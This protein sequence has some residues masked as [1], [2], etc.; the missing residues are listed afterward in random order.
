VSLIYLIRHGTNDYVATG[1]LAGRTPGV[2][3]NEKGRAESEL[4]ALALAKCSINCIWS[5]PLERAR[6]T[7]APLAKSLNL[8]INVSDA[9]LEIDFGKWIGRK[10]DELQANDAD[11]QRWNQYRSGGKAPDGETFLQVQQR[12]VGLLEA[13]RRD[14]PHDRI[15]VFT[16]GDPLRSVVQYYMGMS[17]DLFHRMEIRPASYSAIELTDWGAR[18]QSLN[19]TTHLEPLGGA[20]ISH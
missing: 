9:L 20:T 13:V 3:L 11:W 19:V 2:H 4:L 17:L 18:L 6:E 16:H 10:F 14:R 15:A 12:M 1:R 5:S 7:A 8:E